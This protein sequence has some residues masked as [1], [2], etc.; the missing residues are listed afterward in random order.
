[1]TREKKI[2]IKYVKL[3]YVYYF[4]STLLTVALVLGGLNNGYTQLDISYLGLFTSTLCVICLYLHQG[5]LQFPPQFKLYLFFLAFLLTSFAWTKNPIASYKTFLLFVSGALFWIGFYNAKYYTKFN[6]DQ[7]Y[8][9]KFHNLVLLLGF[10]FA[11]LFLNM[12]LAGLA[13][14]NSFS[15]YKYAASALNHNHLGDLWAVVLLIFFYRALKSKNYL[16]LI[17]V[18]LG[19][20]IMIIS[21]SRSAYIALCAGLYYLAKKQGWI[22]KY[23]ALFVTTLITFAMLFLIIGSQKSIIL[24]RQ[25]YFQALLGILH[26]PFGVGLGNFNA[27]SANPI[28]HFLGLAKFSSVAH[29]IILEVLVGIGILGIIFVYWLAKSSY[30]LWNVDSVDGLL[31]RAIFITLT[32]NFMFDFTYFIPTM[33]WLWFM[34]LGLSQAGYKKQFMGEKNNF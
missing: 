34:S 15:L 28:N 13:Q 29:N 32:V 23:K 20:Y 10:V 26:E 12:K 24:S 17:L 11:G 4:L 18:P 21:Q 7:Y 31:T 33:L 16:W 1:M 3:K 9:R 25:Y 27:V 6:L 14:V 5:K 30:D 8:H 19:L 22:K 2:I